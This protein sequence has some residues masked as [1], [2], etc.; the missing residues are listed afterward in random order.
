MLKSELNFTYLENQ[1]QSERTRRSNERGV[2]V[3]TNATTLNSCNGSVSL[4]VL[5]FYQ[6]RKLNRSTF[7]ESCHCPCLMGQ[8]WSS[9]EIKFTLSLYP[10]GFRNNVMQNSSW[11]QKSFFAFYLG[12]RNDKGLERKGYTHSID[13][14]LHSFK[15]II[16]TFWNSM[17]L[18]ALTNHV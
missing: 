9:I 7:S 5:I 14:I 12:A 6:N 15:H 16:F 3:T 18:L 1:K 10:Y 11:T 13:D 17:E 4:E 2:R 8:F